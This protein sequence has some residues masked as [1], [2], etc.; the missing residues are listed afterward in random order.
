[1]VGTRRFPHDV[2]GHTVNLAQRL[3]ETEPGRINISGST[4]HRIVALFE[5][6]PRGTVAKPALAADAAGC[7]SNERFWQASGLG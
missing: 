3:E 5:T 1:M 6:E 2:W 4:R 7:L